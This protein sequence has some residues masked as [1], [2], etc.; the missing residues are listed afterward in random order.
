MLSHMNPSIFLTLINSS[1]YSTTLWLH[2]LFEK[3]MQLKSWFG[4]G[5]KQR[6]FRIHLFFFLFFQLVSIYRKQF[7]IVVPD[8]CGESRAWVKQRECGTVEIRT[9]GPVSKPPLRY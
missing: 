1:I 4:E 8:L 7:H 3:Y 5:E 2:M 9:R 6:M